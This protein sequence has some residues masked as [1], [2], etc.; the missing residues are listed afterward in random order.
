[1][2]AIKVKF[3]DHKTVHSRGIV[4]QMISEEHCLKIMNLYLKF[5]EAILTQNGKGDVITELIISTKG[6]GAKPGKIFS[7]LTK[8][9]FGKPITFG[10]LRKLFETEAS[11]TDLSE[12]DR[13]A[14]SE[15]FLHSR[16]VAENYYVS[17]N[18]HKTVYSS[19]NLLL[20][21]LLL[22]CLL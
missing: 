1:M 10:I 20:L 18:I 12:G 9:L 13:K 4:E 16:D 2:T 14:Y 7:A 8:K 15:N 17:K 3:I 19:L 22:N 6:V 21:F 5:R 11:E